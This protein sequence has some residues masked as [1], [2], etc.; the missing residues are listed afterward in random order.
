MNAA[1]PNNWGRCPP[2]EWQRLSTTLIARKWWLLARNALIGVAAVAL[3]GGGAWIAAKK[4]S[5]GS[6]EQHCCPP[7]PCGIEKTD[8][9]KDSP[10][11]PEIK[12]H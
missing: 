3:L 4:F 1:N 5:G 11:P 12:N 8:C 10:T 9:P 6:N 2:G 7:V